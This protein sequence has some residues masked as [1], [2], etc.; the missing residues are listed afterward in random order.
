[1]STGRQGAARAVGSVGRSVGPVA[2]P[3]PGPPSPT[4]E[5]PSVEWGH[6]RNECSDG[7]R[8]RHH[9]KFPEWWLLMVTR[10]IPY[11]SD[12]NEALQ[13]AAGRVTRF[14]GH[15]PLQPAALLFTQRAVL[16][17]LVVAPAPVTESW[18]MASLAAVSG[19]TRWAHNTGQPLTRH[20]VFD[21]ETRYRWVHGAGHL[22]NDSARMYR[23]RL[24]LIGDHLNGAVVKRMPRTTETYEAPLKP[25][26]LTEEADLWGWSRGLR[27]LSRRQRVQAS[28]VLGLG[29]GLTRAEKFRVA[30]EHIKITPEGVLVTV[31]NSHTHDVRT[32]ASRRDW[33]ERLAALATAT[34]PGHYLM[35]PWRDTPPPP[36][37]VDESMR[38]AGKAWPPVQFNNH[39][40][41]NT[42][43][44]YHLAVGTPLRVLMEAA[45][46]AGA[47]HLHSLM[48][49]LPP[50]SPTDSIAALRGGNG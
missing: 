33:E 28:V 15:P 19:I 37:A 50:V 10:G 42:W 47:N 36:S 35:A 21:E 46:L 3:L 18:V 13:H 5:W 17:S 49:F 32:I 16:D 41:R 48:P 44:C 7:R 23:V 20:H 30:R 39:R 31:S 14:K 9:V 4:V 8:C 34:A 1:M 25:L 38:R 6:H 45:D 43:L 26:S 24:E 12:A 40:L 27:P 22:T 2:R 11:S 29:V